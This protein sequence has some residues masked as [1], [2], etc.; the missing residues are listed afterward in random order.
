MVYCFEP[1]QPE[2]CTEYVFGATPESQRSIIVAVGDP[3]NHGMARNEVLAFFSVLVRKPV[4]VHTG[5]LPQPPSHSPLRVILSPLSAGTT[6]STPFLG[7][8]A[9]PETSWE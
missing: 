5:C 4:T 1:S 3:T 2:A 9:L 7:L 8:R 6:S